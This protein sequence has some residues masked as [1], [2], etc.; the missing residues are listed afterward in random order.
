MNFNCRAVLGSGLCW[1]AGCVAE[2]SPVPRWR[3][4]SQIDTHFNLGFTEFV[5]DSQDIR[6]VE[7][8]LAFFKEYPELFEA[9]QKEEIIV[10]VDFELKNVKALSKHEKMNQL[11]AVHMDVVFTKLRKKKS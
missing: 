1:A 6:E 3:L 8:H 2:H 9:Q 4:A 11:T 7:L 5:S 10:E